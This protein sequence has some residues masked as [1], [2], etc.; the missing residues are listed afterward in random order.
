[1]IVLDLGLER[2]I[3]LF[4]PVR[5]QAIDADGIGDGTRQDM[6]SDLRALLQHD[7]GKLGIDLLQP[8]RSRRPAGPPPTITTSNS[9]LSRSGSSIVS[10][11]RHSPLGRLAAMFPVYEYLFA[12]HT[13]GLSGR[14]TAVI[15]ISR[16]DIPL[17]GKNYA[18]FTSTS[19]NKARSCHGRPFLL[20]V[21]RRINAASN[22]RLQN[23]SGHQGQ[24]RA[25]AGIVAR[26]WLTASRSPW[27]AG[28]R[29][30]FVRPQRRALEANCQRRSMPR[31]GKA[32]WIWADLSEGF[33]ETATAAVKSKLG[34]VDILINNTGG[35]TPGT[36]E[37][38]T[39]ERLE[40]YFFS[41][42]LR[43]ITLTNALLPDMKQQG[44][45][46]I[47]TVA[48]SGVIDRSAISLSNTL[49][50]RSPAGARRWPPKSAASASPPTCCFPAAS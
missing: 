4:T 46:R 20:I 40:T 14:E 39:A 30:A 50:L 26:A 45:G 24:T 25:R 12:K 49:R 2:V 33:V 17:H 23:G 27:R 38:M 3:G 44:W 10:V 41:M 22:R 21:A 5:Q 42:V 8:D 16:N 15:P 18:A 9:M 6:R 29:C 1:M 7:D 34:G 48:S 37:D 11:I 47:L 31:A 36:T 35:P 13:E 32:D 28:R 19:I 43:V